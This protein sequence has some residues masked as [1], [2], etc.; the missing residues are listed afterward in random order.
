MIRIIKIRDKILVDF[1]VEEF[2]RKVEEF[3]KSYSNDIVQIRENTNIFKYYARRLVTPVTDDEELIFE[4][5]KFNIAFRIGERE[6]TLPLVIER[7]T[8]DDSSTDYAVADRIKMYKEKF[9]H[10]CNEVHEAVLNREVVYYSN[11]LKPK[12]N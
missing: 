7:D 5:T 11:I 10:L 3:I 2:E 12:D 6:I 4:E 1:D 8:L 9:L